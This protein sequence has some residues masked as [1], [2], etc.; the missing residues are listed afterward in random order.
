MKNSKGPFLR[1]ANAQLPQITNKKLRA[2]PK[3]KRTEKKSEREGE[4]E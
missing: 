1:K 2:I 3:T 4:R